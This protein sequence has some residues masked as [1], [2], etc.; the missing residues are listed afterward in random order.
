MLGSIEDAPVRYALYHGRRGRELPDRLVG[1]S[2]G[3]GSM[4]TAVYG[5][6]GNILPDTAK[7][8]STGYERTRIK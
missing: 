1:D 4:K 2:G 5:T 6:A 8:L 3:G 7:M